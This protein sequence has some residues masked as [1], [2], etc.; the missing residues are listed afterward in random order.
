MRRKTRQRLFRR[1]RACDGSAI[2]PGATVFTTVYAEGMF[3][4]GLLREQF[5]FRDAHRW[6]ALQLCCERAPRSTK[7]TGVPAL[8]RGRTV[9]SPT[10]DLPGSNYSR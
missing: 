10:V 9:S 5:A 8:V 1:P 2:A 7:F 4:L 3:S 6:L